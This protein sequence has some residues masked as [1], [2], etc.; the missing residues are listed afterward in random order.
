MCTAYNY[1]PSIQTELHRARSLH[2][3]VH[4]APT[5]ADEI[6]LHAAQLHAA[7]AHNSAP[8]PHN[9]EHKLLTQIA[10]LCIRR[11]HDARSEPWVHT[12]DPTQAEPETP[13]TPTH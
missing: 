4:T 7:V 2:P 10:A 13:K 6:L 9:P 5:A 12:P 3:T 1:I 8:D 11:L